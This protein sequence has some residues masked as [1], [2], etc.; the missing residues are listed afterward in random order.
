MATVSC[1]VDQ[2][3]EAGGWIAGYSV[4]LTLL[5]STQWPF[6]ALLAAY[7]L[8]CHRR[9]RKSFAD[10]IIPVAPCK[11]GQEVRAPSPRRGNGAQGSINERRPPLPPPAGSFSPSAG[12][13]SSAEAPVNCKGRCITS[14]RVCGL[15]RR[16]EAALIPE[17]QAVCG[18]DPQ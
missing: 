11:T 2:P 3:S 5:R 13:V 18:L 8:R 10:G 7:R 4:T 16:I 9:K 17:K 6:N 12:R 1:H 15:F 14:L